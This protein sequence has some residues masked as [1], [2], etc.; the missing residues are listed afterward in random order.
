MKNYSKE[1]VEKRM[2]TQIADSERLKFANFSVDNNTDQSNLKMQVGELYK[3]LLSYPKN[4]Q[5]TKI[6]AII[7]IK[8]A[9]NPATMAYLVFLIPT[10]PK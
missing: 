7:P 3:Q 6:A 1:E 9:N 10:E 8:S 4:K 2:E 5:Q